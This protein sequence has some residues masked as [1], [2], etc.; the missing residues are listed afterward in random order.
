MDLYDMISSRTVELMHS[1]KKDNTEGWHES[2]R[3]EGSTSHIIERGRIFLS[4]FTV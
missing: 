2:E 1:D 3:R 4:T